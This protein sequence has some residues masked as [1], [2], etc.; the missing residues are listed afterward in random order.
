MISGKNNLQTDFE[1]KKI[2]ARKYQAKKKIPT[3]KKSLSRPITLKNIITPLYVRTKILSPEVRG[4][5]K[6][7]PKPKN[8]YHPQKVKWSAPNFWWPDS[9]HLEP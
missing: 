5:K 3:P 8:S 6:L 1:G 2:L 4:Q 9:T 7:F